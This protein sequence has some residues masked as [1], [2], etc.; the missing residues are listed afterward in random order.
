MAVEKR[1]LTAVHWMEAC[2]L[3]S[4]RKLLSS[5][6]ISARNCSVRANP[7]LR[8]LVLAPFHFARQ[9]VAHLIMAAKAT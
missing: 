9:E 4:S 2:A 8:I 3:H 5:R 7:N 6:S 1:N